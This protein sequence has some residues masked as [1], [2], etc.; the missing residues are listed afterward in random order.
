M[1]ITFRHVRMP[2]IARNLVLIMV[3]C[4]ATP[5]FPQLSLLDPGFGQ[6]GQVSPQLS[7]SGPDRAGGVA[8]QPDGRVL[9]AARRGGSS[10]ALVA[11]RLLPTG[12][13]DNSFSGNGIASVPIGQYGEGRSIAALP[14]GSVYLAGNAYFDGS[15][16]DLAVARL[17]PAGELD[18]A[19]AGNGVFVLADPGA[20]DVVESLVPLADGRVQLGGRFDGARSYM[21][22]ARLT[23]QGTLDATFGAGGIFRTTD[24]TGESAGTMRVRST[25]QVVLG[26]AWQMDLPT[27]DLAVLQLSAD[28]SPDAG[29]GTNGLFHPDV[30][31]STGDVVWMQEVGDGKLLI[32]GQR[33]LPG[34]SIL[35]HYIGRLTADG[36]WDSSFGTNGQVVIAVGPPWSADL[37]DVVER[38]DGRFLLAFNAINNN[39]QTAALLVMRLLPDGTP[40]PGFGEDGHVVMPC[41]G[42][43]CGLEAIALQPDNKVVAVGYRIDGS[44]TRAMVQRWLPE[45]YQVGINERSEDAGAKPYPMPCA[46][47]LVVPW[48]DGAGAVQVAWLDAQGRTVADDAI[49]AINTGTA[50]RIGVPSGLSAGTYALRLTH[51][52][53]VRMHRVQVVR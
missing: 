22:C 24:T 46:T 49:H 21:M 34:G 19:F 52:M 4:A 33:Y 45:A 43:G 48:S 5:A 11:M 47:E 16:N 35:N 7:T 39:D 10:P 37:R 27:G 26:G 44:V 41:P 12:A 32:A 51:G 20:Q 38:A 15:F 9:V 40:D 8:L 29:F 18:P 3:A 28:G 1:A 36:Q 14:D 53:Q 17:T 30:P 2:M 13:F 31:G 23:A 25:G 42:Q 6:G 50:L